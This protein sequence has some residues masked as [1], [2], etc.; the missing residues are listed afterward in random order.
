MT[1]IASFATVVGVANLCETVP[2]WC[3][4]CAHHCFTHLEFFRSSVFAHPFFSSHQFVLICF[5]RCQ[6][7]RLFPYHFFSHS[8]DVFG[9]VLENNTIDK[10]SPPT[11]AW[12]IQ[13]N[14]CSNNIIYHETSTESNSTYEDLK[15]QD[16]MKKREAWKYH[17][18]S[19]FAWKKLEF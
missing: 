4:K 10:E 11:C 15:E 1:F 17:D 6:S 8:N 12:M 2:I 14:F 18:T 16:S 7:V 3:E 5:F 19:E 13:S 9:V